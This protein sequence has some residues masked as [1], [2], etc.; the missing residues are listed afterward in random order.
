MFFV[1]I[2]SSPYNINMFKKIN[3][4][5]VFYEDKKVKSIKKNFLLGSLFFLTFGSFQA[6]ANV[7]S[8]QSS[9]LEEVPYDIFIKDLNSR[10]SK[11][12]QE[13]INEISGD[14]FD[15]LQIHFS[16]G[17]I[18]SVDTFKV[19]DH[20][21][22]RVDDGLQLGVGIDLFSKNWLAEGLL[23]NYGRST[24]NDVKISLREF[25]LRL[26][27]LQNTSKSR[28]QFRFSNGL[29]A[30]YLKYQDLM[31]QWTQYQTTPVYLLG[32]GLI[33]PMEKHFDFEIDI[34]GFAPLVSD[35]IDRQGLSVILKLNNKF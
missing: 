3:L 29:G 34:H 1:L 35:S 8:N 28:Y 5:Q 32:M 14:P 31:S 12:S 24:Q 17:Y 4:T 9:Q 19:N 13:R 16:L 20:S 33:F 30:R 25:D 23:K 27:F 6:I 21:M 22:S 11:Q 26:S 2:K 18:Q 15:E 10:V 7:H